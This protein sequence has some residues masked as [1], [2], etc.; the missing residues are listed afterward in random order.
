MRAIFLRHIHELRTD[1]THRTILIDQFID[2][3]I[4]GDCEVRGRLHDMIITIKNTGHV[5]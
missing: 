1:V 4:T 5:G 2:G 3:H